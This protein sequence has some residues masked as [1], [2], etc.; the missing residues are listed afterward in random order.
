[1]KIYRFFLYGLIG[2]CIEITWTGFS[3]MLRGDWS[4]AGKTYLW[5]LPIYGLGVL[6]EPIHDYIRSWSW[7]LRGFVW[8]SLIWFIEFLTGGTLAVTVGTCPWDYSGKTPYSVLGLIR[9]D[10]A[11]AWFVLGLLF[12]RLHDWL[13]KIE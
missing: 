4:L 7:V 8:L 3:S 11:P 13:K 1:M 12:E 5:M 6:L 10:Y 9:L 2:W